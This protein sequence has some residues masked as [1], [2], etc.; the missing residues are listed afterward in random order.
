MNIIFKI[1]ERFRMITYKLILREKVI[2]KIGSFITK[3]CIFEG[4]NLVGKGTYL[5]ESVLGFASYIADNTKISNCIIGRYTSIGPN[6]RVI[7]GQHPTEEF[8]STHPLFYSLGNQ[9]GFSYV[10]EQK[11]SEFRYADHQNSW[12]VV[13]G[14]DVWIGDSV[15]IMEGV[16]IEDGAVVAAGAVV[17][18]NVPSYA[19]VGGVPAKFIKY[20]FKEEEIKFLLDF[21]WWNKDKQWIKENADCFSS[22]KS[23]MNKYSD[24]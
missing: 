18:K 10:N 20:R 6:V 4:G 19:I 3:G 11:F 9:V 2:F 15:K 16:T 7:Q 12:S 24:N 1:Q 8:V 21:K 23:F 14:N 13:I 17:T 5:Y 22:I